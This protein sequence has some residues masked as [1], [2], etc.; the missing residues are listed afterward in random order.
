MRR[1]RD[2]RGKPPQT[3]G[4]ALKKDARNAVVTVHGSVAVWQR[5]GAEVATLTEIG[6]IVRVRKTKPRRPCRAEPAAP[7]A[8]SR[9]K[10]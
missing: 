6:I 5:R 3:E 8:A 2:V 4:V 7:H 9:A 1:C 10:K